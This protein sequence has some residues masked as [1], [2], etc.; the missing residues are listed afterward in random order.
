MFN[1]TKLTVLSTVLFSLGTSPLGAATPDDLL[2]DV[3]QTDASRLSMLLEATIFGVDVAT[4]DAYLDAATAAGLAQIVDQSKWGELAR[5]RAEAT[6][7]ASDSFAVSMRFLRDVSWERY[8]ENTRR[9]IEGGVEV[10]VI[11][12]AEFERLWAQY[13]EDFASMND[14]GVKEGDTIYYRIDAGRVQ[15]VY[16]DA[17]GNILVHVDRDGDERVR[18]T[19]GAFFGRESEFQEDLIRSLYRG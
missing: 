4:V 15:T 9:N 8:L 19:R 7:L 1:L 17:A 6:L 14:R 16:Y 12:E 2:A 3:G 13:V 10:G 11:T 18:S 5:K